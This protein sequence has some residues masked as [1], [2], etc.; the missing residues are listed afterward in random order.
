MYFLAEAMHPYSAESEKE[1]SFSKGDY[2]C[3]KGVSEGECNGKSGWFPF[4]YV[5]KRQRIP[6]T[7]M[8]GVVY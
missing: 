3:T 5:E 6:T 7:N 8:A 4:A 2:C 1:L